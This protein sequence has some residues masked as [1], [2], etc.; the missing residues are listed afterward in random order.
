MSK[1]SGFIGLTQLKLHSERNTFGAQTEISFN[2]PLSAMQP[3]PLSEMPSRISRLRTRL[4][5]LAVSPCGIPASAT[6]AVLMPMSAK[7]SAIPCLFS[8]KPAVPIRFK[9]VLLT[10]M[11]L[12]VTT[13]A[14][15]TDTAAAYRSRPTRHQQ[16]MIL[17]LPPATVGIQLRAN[18][19]ALL[20]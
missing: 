4:P 12:S 11:V 15:P 14:L 16:T 7:P 19:N 5:S 13:S 10:K 17:A 20:V 2:K 1:W 8:M 3:R 9:G 6:W 18:V